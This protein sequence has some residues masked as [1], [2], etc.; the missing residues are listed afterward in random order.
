MQLIVDAIEKVVEHIG[1]LRE[2][3]RGRG[4]V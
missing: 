2:K 1:E 3:K 4:Q